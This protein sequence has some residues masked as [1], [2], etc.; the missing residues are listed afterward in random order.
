MIVHNIKWI[1][2]FTLI[3]G[4]SSSSMAFGSQD[5]AEISADATAEVDRAERSFS[6]K[7]ALHCREHELG[8]CE[9]GVGVFQFPYTLIHYVVVG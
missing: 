9:D 5:E 7:L 6:D 2:L 4:L 8:D 3:I 1:L